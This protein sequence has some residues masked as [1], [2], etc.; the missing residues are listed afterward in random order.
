M[1]D[2]FFT[3]LMDLTDRPTILKIN[4]EKFSKDN[5]FY[6]VILQIPTYR[7]LPLFQTNGLV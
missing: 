1:G 2:E 5:D 6:V 4:V 7:Y 3:C